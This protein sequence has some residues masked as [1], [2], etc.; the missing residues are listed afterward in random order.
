MRL[1]SQFMLYRYLIAFQQDKQFVEVR[2]VQNMQMRSSKF[3]FW[4]KTLKFTEWIDGCNSI[5]IQC[6]FRIFQIYQ[7]YSLLRLTFIEFWTFS[8][9]WERNTCSNWD[10]T[11]RLNVIS[12]R[13]MIYDTFRSFTVLEKF[14]R[15]VRRMKNVNNFEIESKA[16]NRER[17]NCSISHSSSS[18]IQELIWE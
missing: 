1:E 3:H 2:N 11:D 5:K 14:S 7:K 8:K 17:Q 10:G 15:K 4:M 12:I 9:L 18:Y 16:R 13:A 6:S